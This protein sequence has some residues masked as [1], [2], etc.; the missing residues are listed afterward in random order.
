MVDD[1]EATAPTDRAAKVRRSWWRVVLDRSRYRDVTGWLHD[2]IA[3]VE[4]EEIPGAFALDST[5]GAEEAVGADLGEASGED[6]LEKRPMKVFTG[7]VRRRVSPV[8]GWV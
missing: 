4:L 7:S 8:R 1:R 3:S 5:A 6:V 2:G